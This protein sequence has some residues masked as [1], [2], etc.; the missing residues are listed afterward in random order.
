MKDC[1]SLK[2][3]TVFVRFL[4]HW[5]K[6]S[7]QN[8]KFSHM[9]AVLQKTPKGFN[10]PQCAGNSP[11]IWQQWNQLYQSIFGN[12][13]SVVPTSLPGFDTKLEIKEYLVRFGL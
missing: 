5:E 12:N 11:S 4:C 6:T 1:I 13:F 9:F 7:V 2:T 10:T 8:C 3:A